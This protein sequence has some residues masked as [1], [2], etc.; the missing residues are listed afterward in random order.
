MVV[1]IITLI[2]G[3]V[4]FYGISQLEKSIGFVGKNRIPDLQTLAVL[5]KERL[6]IRVQTLE[7]YK[8]LNESQNSL[9]TIVNIKQKRAKSWERVDV[10]WDSFLNIPR[11]TE[12]G[13]ALLD[14]LKGEYKAWRD[15]YNKL[16]TIIDKLSNNPS[17]NEKKG[18]F[19]EYIKTEEIMEPISDRMG[20]T[21]DELTNNNNIN[22]NKMVENNLKFSLAIKFVSLITVVV[23]VI[24]AIF[25]GVFI[26]GSFSK[27]IKKT[28]DILDIISSGDMRPSLDIKSSDEIGDMA[29][30]LNKMLDNLNNMMFEVQTTANGILSGANQVSQAS[31]SLSGGATELAS[32]L[33]EISSSIEEM[34]GTIEQNSDN[35]MEG[36]KLATQSSSEAKEGGDAVNRSV[37]S[38]R[39]IAETIQVIAEIANNT[40]MLALNAAIEA[41]RAGEHGEGFAV[42]ATEV[43]KLAERT[44]KAADEIKRLSSD[45][46]MI[47]VSAGELIN[48]VVPTIIKTADMVQEIASASKEQKVGM[49]QLTQ[50]TSQQEQVT[51][52]VSA[53]SE[54]LAS[55]AEEMAGQS[56]SLV[57]LISNFKIRGVSDIKHNKNKTIRQLE[58]KGNLVKKETKKASLDIK[59]DTDFIQL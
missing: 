44:L 41:A 30:S 8:A 15:I 59:E 49:K 2:V 52:L 21:F 16:D 56:Q 33:E 32:S 57:D 31:Q 17:D 55:S 19:L 46:V 42:V 25:F 26:S 20:A 35:A 7:V 23:G 10:A 18:L 45:G 40:N 48:Y 6:A 43:R 37:D 36:A 9:T 54:E 34:M 50:A 27:P 4:G 5:N 38:I 24:I 39:K 1:S 47:S 12:K 51:Q 3:V 29:N 28:A 58:Y 14:K 53:N 13:R 22:T 11:A